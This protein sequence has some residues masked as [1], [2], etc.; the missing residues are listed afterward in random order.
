MIQVFQEDESADDLREDHV[1]DPG[2]VEVQGVLVIIRF[3]EN[4]Q[5][6]KVLLDEIRDV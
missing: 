2:L 4:L 5:V 1:V 3:S 6:E